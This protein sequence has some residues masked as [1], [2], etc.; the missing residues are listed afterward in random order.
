MSTMFKNVGG[1][2]SDCDCSGSVCT[3]QV[4]VGVQCKII[5]ESL[6]VY[7]NLLSA[8]NV[9]QGVQCR[10]MCTSLLENHRDLKGYRPSYIPCVL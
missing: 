8:G 7:S 6:K 10:V 1:V 4:A 3:G 5:M 9:T 2:I